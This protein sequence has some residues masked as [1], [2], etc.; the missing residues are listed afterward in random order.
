[1]KR[2]P[3]LLGALLTSSVLLGPTS[4]L[5]QTPGSTAAPA[6]KPL[7][8]TESAAPSPVITE[9]RRAFQEGIALAKAERWAEALGSLQRSDALH[10]H[11]ITTYNIGYCERELGQLTRARKQLSK[12]LADHRA[13]GSVELPPDLQAAAQQYLTEIEERLARVLV[14]ITPG[15]VAV[16]GRPLE[17]AGSG[18]AYPLL[19]AGTRESG[20]PEVPPSF[21][22]EV[23]LNPGEHRFVL[24]VKDHADVS[25]SRT[26][27]PGSKTTLTLH[28]PEPSPAPSTPQPKP[29]P[30]SEAMPTAK[31]NRTP[32]FIALGVGAVGL[33]IGSVSGLIAFGKKDDV[34]AACE[35]SDPDACTSARDSGNRAADISTVSFIVGG[36]ALATSAVLFLVTRGSAPAPTAT[37]KPGVRPLVGVGTLGLQGHF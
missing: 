21:S 11:A 31:P 26:F 22:F 1:M 10:P 32:A 34:K 25:V 5:A 18:P 23:L 20:P 19:L 16:D 29:K 28:P 3:V 4:A 7:T 13:R 27:A 37:S 15:A 24:A 14:S 2:L 33:T 12:A 6:A 9:A 8:P 36:A 35:G 17:L 30:K